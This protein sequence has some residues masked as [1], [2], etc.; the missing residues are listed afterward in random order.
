MTTHATRLLADKKPGG[1]DFLDYAVQ[2][3]ELADEKGRED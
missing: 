1:M 2:F 3:E